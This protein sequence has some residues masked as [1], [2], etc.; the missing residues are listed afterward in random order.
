MSS[1]LLQ[2]VQNDLGNSHFP[3]RARKAGGTGHKCGE[4]SDL[5]EPR[6]GVGFQVSSYTVSVQNSAFLATVPVHT[7]PSLGLSML[8]E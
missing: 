6:W 1:W 8:I 3:Q 4:E 2:V 5:S 7:V